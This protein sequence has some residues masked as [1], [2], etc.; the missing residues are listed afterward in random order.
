[1][2][3]VAAD[4][5]R[6]VT[7]QR[8]DFQPFRAGRHEHPFHQPAGGARA[9]E[10][11]GRLHMGDDQPVPFAAVAGEDHAPRFG[12]LEPA[13]GGVLH[14]LAHGRQWG[15]EGAAG[16]EGA[17]CPGGAVSLEA[18]VLATWLATPGSGALAETCAVKNLGEGLA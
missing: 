10:R 1:M 15:S 8:H 11:R 3:A 18:L 9:A 12:Q 7:A 2:L 14:D 5:G 13:G 4:V 16:A 6:R 17:I